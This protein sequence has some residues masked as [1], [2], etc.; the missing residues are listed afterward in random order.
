MVRALR[1]FEGWRCLWR[2]P[3]SGLLYLAVPIL[4][5]G[6]AV[7]G[8]A[9]SG[10]D[11]N[12]ETAVIAAVVTVVGSTYVIPRL[13]RRQLHRKLIAERLWTWEKPN[14]ATDVPVLIRELDVDEAKRV[15]RRAGFNPG[16]FMTKLGAPP[17]DARDLSVRFGVQEPEAHPQS[18]SDEDRV[19]RVA[20][21]LSA[22]GIRARV[23]AVDVPGRDAP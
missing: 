19:R 13:S 7:S 3:A 1:E 15:L 16:P 6:L 9:I 10:N 23:A 11:F 4:F 18:A 14:P 12:V 20:E 17:D 5:V 8:A 22:V 2:V 21:A